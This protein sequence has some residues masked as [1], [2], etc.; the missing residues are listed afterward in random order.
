MAELIMSNLNF[1]VAVFALLEL[2]FVLIFRRRYLKDNSRVNLTV[3]LIS[4]VLFLDGFIFTILAFRNPAGVSAGSIGSVRP[5]I[6]A[7]I[8]AG[9]IG[10]YAYKNKTEV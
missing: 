10:F 6:H 5:V 8:L 9:L 4:I 2:E 3:L 7:V 1:I